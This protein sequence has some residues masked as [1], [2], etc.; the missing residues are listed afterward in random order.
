MERRVVA[1]EAAALAV[2]LGHEVL[3]ASSCRSGQEL[4]RVRSG[5]RVAVCHRIF[6]YGDLGKYGWV[7]KMIW[8][9]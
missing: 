6:W 1:E 3:V 2:A 8:H 9:S 7:M 4:R 5:W